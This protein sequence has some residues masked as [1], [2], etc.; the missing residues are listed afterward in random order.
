MDIALVSSLL[1][2]NTYLTIGLMCWLC[3][4]SITQICTSKIKKVS[5]IESKYLF[6]LMCKCMNL[7][8]VRI[9]CAKTVDEIG[10]LI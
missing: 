10:N 1:T 2:L 7:T 4:V 3:S 6:L 5:K 9:S 8:A